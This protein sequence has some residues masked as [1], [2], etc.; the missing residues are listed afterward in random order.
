MYEIKIRQL[1]DILDADIVGPPDSVASVSGVCIDSRRIL[2]GRIFFAIEGENFD[3]HDFVEASFAAGASCAVVSKELNISTQKPQLVV[4]DTVIALGRM[5]RWWRK[6]HNFKVVAITG[7]AGKTTTRRIIAAALGQKFKV[8]QSPKSFNNHI[9]V[10]LT[11]L[12]AEKDCDIIVVELGSNSF[13]EISYLSKIVLPDVALINNVYPVHLEKLGTIEGVIKE[14]ASITD[15]LNENT[16][17]LVNADFIGLT[18]HLLETGH[19]FTTFGTSADCDI[20]AENLYSNGPD[21]ELT[22]DGIKVKIPLAGR[23]NLENA[24]AAWA[25]CKQFGISPA[26]FANAAEYLETSEMRME[27]MSLASITVINDCYNANP[28]SM[29]NALECLRRISD[30]TAARSVFICGPMNELGAESEKLHAEL[31]ERIAKSG[32]KLLLATGCYANVVANT[33]KAAGT[34]AHTFKNTDAICN[35]LAE[36]VEPDDIILVKG[37]RRAKLEKII[38]KLEKL[39]HQRTEN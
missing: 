32:V 34:V 21:G 14:K 15:G 17:L 11:I 12:A 38:V 9:G 2:T 3:G 19:V 30:E 16:K 26:Q 27:I 36:F 28:A 4:K 20:K 24:L 1:A 5:A 29:R 35:K 13:G 25:V 7:S 23:A 39:L 37:S 22:I 8:A 18:G 31:G 10:P 6:E 33:A